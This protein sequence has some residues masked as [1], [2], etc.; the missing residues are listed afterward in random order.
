VWSTVGDLYRWLEA[1]E[2]D[3]I[4]PEGQRRLLHTPPRPPAEE[5]FGWRVE[6][7]PDG[8][9]RC[10]KGGGSDDFASQ[11]LYYPRERLAVIWTNNDRRQRWRKAL[12][13]TLPALVFAGPPLA[14]P[15]VA[16]MAQSELE[17]LAG[18]YAAESGEVEIRAGSG[19]L[20]AAPNGLD[21]SVDVMFFPQ[22]GGRFTA[23]DPGTLAVTRLEVQGKDERSLAFTFPD[24]RR[25]LARSLAGVRRPSMKSE[26]SPSA[27]PRSA[28]QGSS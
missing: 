6:T 16:P 1:L 3:R 19:Y 25:I 9:L 11:L 8:R 15:P 13:E 24:G 10:L 22:G 14:L 17:K 7:A 26:S 23:F 28:K 12:N 2:A 20:F 5:A 27:K 4:L 18:R 21:I